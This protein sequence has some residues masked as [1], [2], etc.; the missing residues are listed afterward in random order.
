MPGA[1]LSKRLPRVVVLVGLPGSGKSSWA[2]RKG[3]PTLSSDA[4]R[5]T[6]A[7]DAT[8]QTIHKQVFQ[9]LRYLLRQRIALG[10]PVTCVDATHLTPREASVFPA[11]RLPRGSGLLQDPIGG[12]SRT[13]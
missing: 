4:M 6:L 5:A 2:A 12:L 9:A 11:A 10:R 3:L 13:Q 8:N 1:T 7:D